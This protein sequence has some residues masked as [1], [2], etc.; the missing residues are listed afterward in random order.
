[1]HVL[2]IEDE[3]RMADTI[4]EAL[5]SQGFTC[6]VV[7]Y[8]CDGTWLPEQA[9]YAAIVSLLPDALGM[10]FCHVLRRVDIHAPMLLLAYDG[11][12]PSLIG[13]LVDGTAPPEP[14]TLPCSPT[15]LSA[16]LRELIR[17]GSEADARSQRA[18]SPRLD[19]AFGDDLGTG[20]QVSLTER[21]E[22]VLAAVASRAPGA[23][24]RYDL[25]HQVWGHDYEGAVRLVDVYV[26]QICKKLEAAGSDL[27]LA[28]IDGVGIQLMAARVHVAA[29]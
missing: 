1:M 2:I 21:E 16:R 24:Q 17:L 18:G 9:R 29:R 3:P 14:L 20:L 22:A 6:H 28:Y 15:E 8:G 12:T 23:I 25:F 26:D 7:F 10:H 19:G 5:T 4:A 13:K 11:E 27:R